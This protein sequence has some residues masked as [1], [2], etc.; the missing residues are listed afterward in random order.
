M[1]HYEAYVSDELVAID[2]KP[3]EPIGLLLFLARGAS[4]IPLSRFSLRYFEDELDFFGREVW[5]AAWYVTEHGG[6]RI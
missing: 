2:E 3:Y 5:N 1:Q 4:A 6:E